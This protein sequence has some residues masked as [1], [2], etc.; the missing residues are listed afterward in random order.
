MQT[1][2]APGTPLV[3][4]TGNAADPTVDPF[5]DFPEVVVVNGDGTVNVRVP[6]NKAPG[7]SGVEH[8]QRLLHLRPAAVRR[9]I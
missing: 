9:A 8:K 3:E 1:G 2:F 7:A 5:N 6:R 4:L